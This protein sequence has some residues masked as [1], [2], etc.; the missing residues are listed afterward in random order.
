[1]RFVGST[2][3]SRFPKVLYGPANWSSLVLITRVINLT[4]LILS[5]MIQ[6]PISA[7]CSATDKTHSVILAYKVDQIIYF[8]YLIIIKRLILRNL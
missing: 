2:C 3:C 5:V 4:Y 7:Y 6:L 8:G 1:M